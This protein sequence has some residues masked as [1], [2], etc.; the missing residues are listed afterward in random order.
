MFWLDVMNYG[1]VSID[2]V[3]VSVD[4]PLAKYSITGVAPEGKYIDNRW[5]GRALQWPTSAPP[6]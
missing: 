2:G 6:A 4:G 5:L 3:E 1:E